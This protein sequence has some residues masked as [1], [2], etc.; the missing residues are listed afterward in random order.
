MNLT[1]GIYKYSSRN[2][3]LF[4]CRLSNFQKRFS[5]FLWICSSR[6]YT[7]LLLNGVNAYSTTICSAY[8]QSSSSVSSMFTVFLLSLP[9]CLSHRYF[10][11]E[12]FFYLEFGRS[13][14]VTTHSFI[15]SFVRS[16][17]SRCVCTGIVQKW[18]E[19]F[20]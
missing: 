8:F 6:A 11:F 3:Y 17:C 14:F 1:V 16:V 12:I 5:L 20:I 2:A 4:S 9:L 18:G 13:H 19:H 10:S 7:C 15:C